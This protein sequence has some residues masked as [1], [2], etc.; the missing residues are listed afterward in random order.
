M[1]KLRA[2]FRAI[3]RFKKVDSFSPVIER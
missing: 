2:L 3:I 1:K